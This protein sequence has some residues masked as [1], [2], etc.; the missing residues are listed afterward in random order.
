MECITFGCPQAWAGKVS[1]SLQE[2][3]FRGSTHTVVYSW[4][5]H[6]I[7]LCT[8]R[9]ATSAPKLRT[10]PTRTEQDPSYNCDLKR[11]KWQPMCVCVCPALFRRVSSR[12][13]DQASRCSPGLTKLGSE[14]GSAERRLGVYLQSASQAVTLLLHGLLHGFS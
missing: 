2:P 10:L 8:K 12:Q 6:A 14:M 11:S 7:P 13:G 3:S 9:L 1:G 5:N 4:Q